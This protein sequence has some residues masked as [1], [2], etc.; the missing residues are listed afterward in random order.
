LKAVPELTIS[1]E[2]R[3][4][5]DVED[6]MERSKQNLENIKLQLFEKENAIAMLTQNDSF[7]KEAIASLSDQLDKLME[8]IDKIKKEKR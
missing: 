3:I 1:R 5:K 2:H 7:N 8:E 4:Q 6:M